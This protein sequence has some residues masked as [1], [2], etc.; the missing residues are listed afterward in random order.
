M[1]HHR[2]KKV[3]IEEPK[4]WEPCR[5]EMVYLNLLFIL[6]LNFMKKKTRKIIVLAVFIIC[7]SFDAKAFN[8]MI[9]IIIKM[10]G[11]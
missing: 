2:N 4:K 11:C 8:M 1:F 5:W 9:I 10:V 6:F 7:R 3:K